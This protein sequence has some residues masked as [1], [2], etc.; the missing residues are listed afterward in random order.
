MVGIDLRLKLA[1]ATSKALTGG[2]RRLGRGGGTAFPGM[3]AN[4]IDPRILE[5]LAGQLPHGVAI[6]A[7]TNGKTTSSR[8]L[9][10]V[11]QASGHRVVHNR[12]GSNLV[13]GISGAFAEEASIWGGCPP[14]IGVIEADENALPDVIRQTNPRLILL[15][16]L[17]RDQLDRYGE[18]ETITR[19]WAPAIASLPADTTLVVNADDPNLAALAETS[20]ARVVTFGLETEGHELPELPHAADAA[21]CRR[22]ETRFDYDAIYVSHLGHYHCPNCGYRRPDLDVAATSIDFEGMER[23]RLGFRVDKT[24]YEVDVAL[25]G[26]YNAYNALGVVAASHALGIPPETIAGALG[27]FEA[28]FGRLEKINYR[29]RHLTLALS[30]NPV[31]FNEVLRMLTTEPVTSPVIVGINDLYADGT[32]IS[33][34]W[35]VD[36]ETLASEPHTG[37]I[38]P[39]GIRGD[40]LAVRMKYAGLPAGRLDTSLLDLSFAEVVRKLPEIIAEGE[41]VFVLLTYTAMLQ[42]R[43]ALADAGVTTEFWKQ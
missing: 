21:F 13:R 20:N 18:L 33:W 35:D 30:K 38:L 25:P 36:F 12:S 40:D 2:I 42:L 29:G 41:Q 16:N 14:D 31:G 3:V 6:V 28:A 39:A 5:K 32:D 19:L 7:G 26:L 24:P 1:L 37:M 23:L 22:C 27:T 4:R 15:L 10:N 17:F 9:A 34:L 11:L 43:R 8:M